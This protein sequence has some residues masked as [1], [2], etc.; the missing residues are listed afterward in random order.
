MGWLEFISSMTASLAWPL[1]VVVISLLFRKPLAQVLGRLRPTRVTGPGGLGVEFGEELAQMEAVANRKGIPSASE[2]LA[3][4]TQRR[5]QMQNKSR[6][7]DPSESER[8]R[9]GLAAGVIL[10]QYEELTASA[11]T[12]PAE[13]VQGAWSMVERELRQAAVRLGIMESADAG[14]AGLYINMLTLAA[15]GIDQETANILRRLYRLRNVAA[16]V[17][18]VAVM[19][20]GGMISGEEAAEY[21]RLAARMAAQLASLQRTER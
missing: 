21:V 12:F 11:A 3:T 4:P 13:A 18:D 14:S 6:S 8:T 9:F 10:R 5:G 16:H 2:V 20:E 15:S 7:T 17:G 1:A 19:D